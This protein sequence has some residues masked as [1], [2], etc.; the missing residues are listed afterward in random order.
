[1]NNVKMLLDEI[2]PFYFFVMMMV[3]MF[4]SHVPTTFELY[5][6]YAFAFGVALFNNILYK[7]NTKMQSWGVEALEV[8]DVIEEEN[9][10]LLKTI[11]EQQYE[12]ELMKSGSDSTNTSYND[13]SILPKDM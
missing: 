1:M 9:K 13:G 5:I 6:V 3:I 7:D 4:T 8:I 10:A 2:L 11:E 12:L